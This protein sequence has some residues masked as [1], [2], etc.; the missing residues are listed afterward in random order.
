ME[1][2]CFTEEILHVFFYFT[3]NLC[4]L[5]TNKLGMYIQIFSNEFLSRYSSTEWTRN[6]YWVLH[7]IARKD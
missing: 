6:Q 7:K 5:R 3:F 4:F 2:A 1:Q